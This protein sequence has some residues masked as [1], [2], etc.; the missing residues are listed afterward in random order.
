MSRPT[1][2]VLPI[3][4]WRTASGVPVYFVHTPEIGMLDVRLMFHA[5]AAR[6]G[7]TL[8]VDRKS[9]V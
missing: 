7:D 8:G 9:V 4:Y 1:H 3:Q 2:T 6:D 5:G